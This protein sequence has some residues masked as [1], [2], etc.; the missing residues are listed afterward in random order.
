MA[1]SDKFCKDLISFTTMQRYCFANETSSH[2]LTCD[3]VRDIDKR[4]HMCEYIFYIAGVIIAGK[5]MVGYD[6]TTHCVC[7]VELVSGINIFKLDLLRVYISYKDDPVCI[8]GKIAHPVGFLYN[9]TSKNTPARP[10]WERMVA[11][12]DAYANYFAG[13]GL[14]FKHPCRMDILYTMIHDSAQ[15]LR[16]WLRSHENVA[17]TLL[18]YLPRDLRILIADMI[19][20]SIP[21]YI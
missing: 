18:W 5:L 21:R 1:S 3:I 17:G 14:D 7:K 12:R 10:R 16:E 19:I 20:G 6:C 2:T 8:Y 9:G 13:W 11:T 4:H 15:L